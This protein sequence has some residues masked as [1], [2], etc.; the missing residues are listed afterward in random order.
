M[1]KRLIGKFAAAAVLAPALALAGTGQ[2]FAASQ[3]VTWKNKGNGKY[4][5]YFN[6]RVRTTSATG[7]T[8]KWTETK[9][10]GGSF[11]LKHR[12]TGKCLDSNRHGAVYVGACNGGNH[13]KWYEIK[14]SAGWRLKNKATG[15][16]LGVQ[17]SGIAYTASDTRIPRQ[18]WS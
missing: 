4:L 17:P 11:T 10:S 9:Q 3:T 7:A 12:M 14:D 13:Q 5:A 1:K 6:G 15:R 8:M 2:A 18:R 16:T